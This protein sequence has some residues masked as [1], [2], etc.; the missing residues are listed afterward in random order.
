MSFPIDQ[1]TTRAYTL[2][3]HKCCRILGKKNKYT[4]VFY[5]FL[6]NEYLKL[7]AFYQAILIYL[8]AILFLGDLDA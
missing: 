8:D 2:K 6:K 1:K 4:L 5:R 7:D 3:C